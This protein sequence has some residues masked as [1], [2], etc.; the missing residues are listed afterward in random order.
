MKPAA[1][2]NAPRNTPRPIALRLAAS[3]LLILA[4]MPAGAQTPAVERGRYLASIMDC[5]GCHAPRD[6]NG[7]P[8]P[9]A[10]LSG[11]T[12]GF[13]VPGLGAFWPPNLTPHD[14]GLGGWTTVD[15]IAAIRSGERPDGRLLAPAMPFANYAHLTDADAAALAAYLQSLEPVDHQVP[16]PAGPGVDTPA[17]APV[18]RFVAPQ[19]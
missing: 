18:F 16:P 8:L 11:G 10:G 15:I 6:A 7:V 13:E 5:G 14:T 9:G 1:C 3:A 12:V 17:P 19:D 2:F 4:A